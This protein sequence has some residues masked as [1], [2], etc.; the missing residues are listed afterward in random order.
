[1]PDQTINTSIIDEEY[2]S[3]ADEAVE[4]KNKDI[5]NV[6]VTNAANTV[7][8]TVTTDY[9]I[10]ALAGKITTLS[11]GAID[12]N[13]K[14][15]IDYDF[16]TPI[17][18][19][20]HNWITEVRQT[21][22]HR[23]SIQLLED[24]SEQRSARSGQAENKYVYQIDSLTELDSQSFYRK[25]IQCIGREI[26]FPDFTNFVCSKNLALLGASAIEIDP[27]TTA[28]GFVVGDFTLV[29]RDV[30]NWDA[31]LIDTISPADKLN[32]DATFRTFTQ[33]YIVGAYVMPLIK[34]FISEDALHKAITDKFSGGLIEFTQIAI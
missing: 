25:M 3:V 1:M 7:T 11:S 29:F 9:T 20:M 2:F 23:V 33:E 22:G 12:D 5:V 19:L 21:I 27:D 8:Y 10:D 26:Y 15:L 14:L 13:E 4:L 18:M 17:F 31:M 32:F 6:V 24:L 30:E 34:G 28:R 16:K